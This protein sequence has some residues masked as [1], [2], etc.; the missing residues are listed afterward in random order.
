[1]VGAM[2]ALRLPVQEGAVLPRSNAPFDPLQ[3][4]LFSRFGVQVPVFPFP[5]K[6]QRVLRVSTPAYVTSADIDRLAAALLEL[7]VAR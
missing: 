6:E 5:G 7:G 1:M 2:A 4:E 3:Q